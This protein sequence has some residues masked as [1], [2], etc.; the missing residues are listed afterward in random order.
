MAMIP[1]END[2]IHIKDEPLD[3]YHPVVEVCLDAGYALCLA[4]GTTPL[5]QCY[6]SVSF[7]NIDEIK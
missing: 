1:R 6:I 2:Y 3:A 4:T 7:D 5:D